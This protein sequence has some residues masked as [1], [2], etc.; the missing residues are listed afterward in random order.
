[1]L[2]DSPIEHEPLTEGERRA[3]DRQLDKLEERLWS[4]PRGLHQWGQGA[5]EAEL[6]KLVEL[7]LHLGMRISVPA[8]V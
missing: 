7:G 8:S 1:M 2:Q 5:G 6:A 4:A 3:L